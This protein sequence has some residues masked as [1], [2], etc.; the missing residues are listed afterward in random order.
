MSEEV[1]QVAFQETLFFQK[2]DDDLEEKLMQQILEFS[3]ASRE[4]L[5]IS[6]LVYAPDLLNQCLLYKDNHC[7]GCLHHCSI[8][9]ALNS[10]G[11]FNVKHFPD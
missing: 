4:C 2:P 11:G 1:K 7:Y 8:K 3:F 6:L 10:N 5:M 9:R